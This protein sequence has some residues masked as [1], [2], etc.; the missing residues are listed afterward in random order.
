MVGIV[1]PAL[2]IFI[3]NEFQVKKKSGAV[4][5]DRVISLSHGLKERSTVQIGENH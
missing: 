5:L 3:E 1:V 4:F 2:T